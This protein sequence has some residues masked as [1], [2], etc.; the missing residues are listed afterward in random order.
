MQTEKLHRIKEHEKALFDFDEEIDNLQEVG[1][2]Y[3][4]M[5][6]ENEEAAE[7]KNQQDEEDK[8]AEEAPLGKQ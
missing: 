7:P 4:G 2:R 5:P 1:E 3:P 8:Q 6:L